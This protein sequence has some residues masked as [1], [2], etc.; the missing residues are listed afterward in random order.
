MISANGK[1]TKNYAY[2]FIDREVQTPMRFSKKDNGDGTITLTAVPTKVIA[3]GTPLNSN[4]F[5]A[6]Q[7]K[8]LMVT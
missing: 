4:V 5:M 8:V 1:Y 3:E 6:M 2:K 7:G